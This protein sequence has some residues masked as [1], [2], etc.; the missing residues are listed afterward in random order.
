MTASPQSTLICATCLSLMVAQAHAEDAVDRTAF[1]IGTTAFDIYGYV[2]ADFYRD[3]DFIQGDSTFANN[4]GEPAF[5]TNGESGAT[6]RQTRIGFRSRTPTE[7]GDLEFHVE[8]DFYGAGGSSNPR[9]RHGNVTLGDHLL[10][11]KTWS[12][13]LPLDDYPVTVDF[14]GPVGIAFALRNQLRWQGRLSDSL[15]YTVAIEENVGGSNSD[16]PALVLSGAWE[17]ANVALW[18]AAIA[19]TAQ[20]GATEVDQLGLTLSGKVNLWQGSTL[21]ATFVSGQAI[22][23]YLVGVGDA[24]VG[25]RANDVTGFTLELRQDLSQRLNVGI[26]YGWEDYDLPSSTGV[27]DFTRLQTLHLNAF[28]S[29]SDQ[30]RI[31][32]EYFTGR[33]TTSGGTRFD[34]DRVQLAAQYFF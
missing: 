32:A 22:G 13:F 20:S 30:F 21:R 29:L 24:I 1:E 8:Y 27:T 4:F 16:D 15:S 11:G 25:G 9:L 33:K 10:I 19:G 2:K 6:L 14:N 26:A 3:F 17:G 5:V 7:L 18:A 28:Y 23:P 34:G 12:N 31:S